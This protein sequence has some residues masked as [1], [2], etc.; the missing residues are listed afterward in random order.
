MSRDNNAPIS[1]RDNLRIGAL[2]TA[3]VELVHG[4]LDILRCRILG[5]EVLVQARR[6]EPPNALTA[7]VPS[8]SSDQA[9]ADLGPD[10]STLLVQ[11]VSFG[12]KNCRLTVFPSSVEPRAKINITS[13]HL[14]ASTSLAERNCRRSIPVGVAAINGARSSGRNAFINIVTRR[15]E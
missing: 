14:P 4:S 15:K 12:G 3:L 9:I 1:T 6:I 8:Q 10:D 7:R 2:G 13:L 5:Q 11:R